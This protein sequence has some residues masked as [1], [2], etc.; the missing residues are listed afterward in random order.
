MQT[1][2]EMIS[3]AKC[4]FRKYVCGEAMALESIKESQLSG[5]K[6]KFMDLK[7]LFNETIPFMDKSLTVFQERLVLQKGSIWSRC[8]FTPI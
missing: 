3:V 7:H 5:Q 4:Q 1:Q 8:Q 6:I 2:G